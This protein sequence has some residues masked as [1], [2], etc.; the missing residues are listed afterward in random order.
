MRIGPFSFT[1]RIV[2]TLAALVLLAVLI[3]LGFW[4]LSRAD[5]K[6]AARA[7]REQRLREPPRN[8][9]GS[10]TD[11]E[12]ML[13]RRVN[14]SGRF[15]LQHQFMLQNQ[16]YREQPGYEIYT[17]LR[18]RDDAAVLVDR[19]W[20]AAHPGM[21]DKPDLSGDTSPIELTAVV[22]AP[23]SIGLKLGEPDAGAT[24]WP[25]QVQYLDLDWA[26]RQLGYRLLPYVLLPTNLATQGFVQNRK[27]E[28]VGE[29]GMPPEKH[30]S[31]AVQWFAMAIVLVLIYIAMNTR[32][33]GGEDER[34]HGDNDPT[35]SP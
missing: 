14:A 31:Y 15:D 32:R 21:D 10:A 27:P 20:V 24:R 8:L 1:P 12:A 9:S 22:G 19:G 26:Q 11:A 18:L 28:D 6:Y 13:A 5:Q 4:Q 23:P 25:R 17:P 16:V 34:D 29:G 7:V 33:I 3:S 2:P 35:D 30:V